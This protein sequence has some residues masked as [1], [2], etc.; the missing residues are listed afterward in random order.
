MTIE[1][2]ATDVTRAE[3]FLATLLTEMI[4]EGKF[5]TGTALRDLTIRAFAFIFA[6]LMKENTTV[7]ALQNLRN[8]Q[9]ISSGDSATDRAVANAVDAI[10]SN[11]FLTR[12]TGSFSR[13]VLTFLVS[14]RQDYILSPTTRFLYSRNLAYFP[15]VTDLE[16][17]I[18]VPSSELVSQINVSGEV[19][20]YIFTQSVVAAETGS[21]YDITPADWLSA[22]DF[23]AYTIKA[24]NTEQ[25]SA[26][27]DRETTT[28]MID[29]SSTA[30]STRNLI[31]LRSI[32]ATLRENF[33][34]IVRL[35]TIGAGDPEMQRDKKIEFASGMELHV[36]G[37]FDTYLELPIVQKTFEGQ[38]GGL[39]TRPDG[40]ASV[41]RDDT[42]V[43]TTWLAL[44]PQLRAGDVIRITAGLDDAPRDFVIHEVQD[45]ELWISTLSPF[46]EATDEDAAFVD[47]SIYRPM[48]GPNAPLYPTTGVVT[49]GQTSRTTR[50][51]ATA[52]LPVGPHYDIIHVAIIDP[53]AGHALI[54]STD[55]TIVFNNRVNTAPAVITNPAE[56]EY[57]ITSSYPD[58]A[59]SQKSYDS[60]ILE[61]A[62]E[63][64]T[65]RVIYETLAG[66]D[67]I[68]EFATDRFERVLAADVLT[69]GF[70]PVY[71]S[72][73][74]E[75]DPKMNATGEVSETAV[76]QGLVSY[77]NGFDPTEILD[78]SDLQVQARNLDSQIGIIYPFE[79]T[80]RLLVPDGRVMNYTTEDKITLDSEKLDDDQGDF[81]NPLAYSLSSRNIRYITRADLVEVNISINDD[82]LNVL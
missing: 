7:Q 70:F 19:E 77:I 3:E 61:S 50:V 14:R 41:F 10:L 76:V 34:D 78:V 31:N 48:H 29:R 45:T 15:D 40:A 68:H 59:Q 65:V 71:I 81:S 42:S 9:N 63:G 36:L 62:F 44:I 12:R 6:H 25:F 39:Y 64:K 16:T 5:T 57:Q 46:S 24:F 54:N 53:D 43:A 82:V 66:A 69:R 58:F 60:I 28:E 67:L 52:V 13:G 55:G 49:T 33:L 2:S 27:R 22:G 18:I 73:S 47:Y 1:I 26:G 32:D 11:W 56:L 38:L 79:V 4:P 21:L 74:M 80:Y 30:I 20:G 23:S 75:Y 17:T 51:E 37:H 72:L 8:V 35:L